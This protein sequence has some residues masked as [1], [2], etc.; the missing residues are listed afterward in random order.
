LYWLLSWSK[1][2][3]CSKSTEKNVGTLI[4]TKW[5]FSYRKMFKVQKNCTKK[6]F[7]FIFFDVLGH[8]E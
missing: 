3:S 1:R 6:N 8:F 7:F 2:K 4:T 5:F